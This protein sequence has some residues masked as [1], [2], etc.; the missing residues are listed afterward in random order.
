MLA[1]VP[2]RDAHDQLLP[3]VTRE[4][5]VDVGNGVEL[6]IDEAPK[7]KAGVDGIDV[8]EPRQVADDRADGAAA[9]STRRERVA[10]R[11]AAPDLV[12]DVPRELEHL[13]V[14]QEE[15]RE[16]ELVDQLQLFVEPSARAAPV[17]VGVAI[18]LVEG[19]I[20]DT[21]E[22]GNRRF[23][24]VREVRIAV[25]ELLG[26]VE[27]AALRD[28]RRALDGGAVE[29]EAVEDLLRR[30]EERLV[31]PT[32]LRLRALQRGA[33][34]DRDQ[35]VLQPR[36]RQVVSVD[37]TRHDRPD[38]QRLGEVAQLRIA[39]DVASLEGPLELDE[40]ALGAKGLREPRRGARVL[41]REAEARAPREAD[42]AVVQLL[43]DRLVERRL[44]R[45]LAL[46]RPGVRVR[47][48]QE[49]AEVR[50][51]ARAL[52]EERDVRA[53]GEG[54]LRSGDRPHPERL[55]RLRELERAVDPVVVGERKRLVAELSR[56]DRQLLGQ[57]GAVEERIG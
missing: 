24:L 51:A 29:R 38:L 19:A 47:R 11:V 6:A 4:V 25:A 44:Q 12:G 13:V 56:P 42:E 41:H 3:D 7:G 8:R 35:R 16:A 18:A 55:R 48:R 26:Q 17:P 27:L 36:P 37:V 15:A 21:R 53:V 20:A 54:D 40:E 28:S 45:R 30:P 22:L 32:P 14:E 9:A 49:P 23:D 46:L 57:R 43:E 33:V 34:P 1:P 2:L 31:V 10:W 52:D 39:P 5:E 50:V